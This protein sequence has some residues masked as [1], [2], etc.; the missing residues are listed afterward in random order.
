MSRR[1]AGRPRSDALA[2]HVRDVVKRL[3]G[4]REGASTVRLA[5]GFLVR[6]V[7]RSAAGQTGAALVRLL[8]SSRPTGK[9]PAVIM[10]DRFVVCS[11]DDWETV[12][13]EVV[14]HRDRYIVKRSIEARHETRSVRYLEAWLTAPDNGVVSDR[15]LV[16][17]RLRHRRTVA[18]VFQ[19]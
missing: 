5:S 4:E 10:N 9:V 14:Q 3:G 1:R 12:W 15:V 19:L 2:R 13:G 18:I 6:C 16:A 8:E 11:L 7:Y 17:V